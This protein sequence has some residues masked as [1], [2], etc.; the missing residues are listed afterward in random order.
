MSIQFEND[1]IPLSRFRASYKEYIESLKKGKRSLVL[2]QNG[3]AAAIV[4]SPQE[5]DQLKAQQ[6]VMNLI[7]S[8]LQEIANQQFVEDDEAMWKDLES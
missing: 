8:R 5:Y 3:K 7:A 6:E 4:L 1:I 2:T